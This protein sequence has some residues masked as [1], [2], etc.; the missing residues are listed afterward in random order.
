MDDHAWSDP[1]EKTSSRKVPD[2]CAVVCE[3]MAHHFR[4]GVP[5]MRLN[6]VKRFWRAEVSLYGA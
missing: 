2:S 1:G 5:G 4:V 6:F 3:Y